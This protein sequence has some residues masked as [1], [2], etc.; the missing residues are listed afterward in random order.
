MKAMMHSLMVVVVA[1]SLLVMS[2]AGLT[3]KKE[4]E[5]TIVL[6]DCDAEPFAFSFKAKGKVRLPKDPAEV[7]V[8]FDIL[9]DVPHGLAANNKS[10][11]P[12]FKGSG[13]LIDMGRKALEEVKEAPKEG[14]QATLKPEQIV[15]GHTYCVLASDGKHYGK[16]HVV[17]FD[18]ERGPI[19]FTW[20]YQPK[21]TNKFNDT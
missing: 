5:K 15:P 12:F 14:Y 6:E 16:V 2:A 10:I 21:D 1:H 19:E 20:E 11:A 13:G 7:A 9:L 4:E 3:D 17:K 18:P 8:D